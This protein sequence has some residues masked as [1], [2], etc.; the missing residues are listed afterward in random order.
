VLPDIANFGWFDYGLRVGFWRLKQVLDGHGIRATVSLNASVCLSYPQIV[1]ESVKAGWELMG[2]GFIQR[3]I[4]TEPDE[5]DVIQRTMRTIKDCTGKA[6]RGWMGRGWPKP[7]LRRISE[8]GIESDGV[9]MTNRAM[10][11][12]HGRLVSILYPGAQRH[13]G[14]HQ[15]HRSPEIFERA[16]ITSG[17]VVVRGKSVAYGHL[18][19]PT[20]RCA[21][22]HQVFRQAVYVYPAVC[23]RGLHDRGEFSIGIMPWPE[24]HC[25]AKGQ[26]VMRELRH[27]ARGRRHRWR[28]FRLQYCLP[29]GQEGQ[30]RWL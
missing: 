2:H 10:K 3:A 20:S 1:A 19:H 14:I 18:Y 7:S 6:P 27:E 16:Q 22:S 15:H 25:L 24:A 29:S 8:E 21:A 12:K 23:W 26:R 28:D 30:R 9:T 17:A 5:R 13:S 11:V 4:N